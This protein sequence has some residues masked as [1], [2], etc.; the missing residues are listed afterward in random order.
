MQI[1]Q[2][3]ESVV[4]GRALLSDLWPGRTAENEK[5]PNVFAVG[6]ICR[7]ILP[8]VSDPEAASDPQVALW[9]GANFSVRA[10]I[11]WILSGDQSLGQQATSLLA[12]VLTLNQW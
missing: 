12:S 9:F 2:T 11:H 6:N 3:G 8:A 1:K 5:V 10:P 7:W 4:D